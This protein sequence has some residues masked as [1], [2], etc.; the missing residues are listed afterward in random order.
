M[1]LP[2][3]FL[4]VSAFAVRDLLPCDKSKLDL[5]IVAATAGGLI[6]GAFIVQYFF[7]GLYQKFYG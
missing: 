5:L 2:V 3:I 6:L 4:I 1:A 7:I